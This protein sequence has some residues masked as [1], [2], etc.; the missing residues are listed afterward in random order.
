MCA[1]DSGCEFGHIGS[2]YDMTPCCSGV[3]PSCQRQMMLGPRTK[4]CRKLFGRTL[5]P[6]SVIVSIPL[7]K[8]AATIWEPFQAAV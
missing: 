1:E 8:E 2:R 7:P 6:T 4:E 5:G 3:S